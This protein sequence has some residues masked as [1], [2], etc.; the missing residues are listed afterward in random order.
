MVVEAM[1]S[2]AGVIESLHVVSGP[3]ML[4]RRRSMRFG[5]RGISLIG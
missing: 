3:E 4:R 1:I 2:K 5:R